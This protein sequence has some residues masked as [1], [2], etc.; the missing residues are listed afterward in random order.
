M[1]RCWCPRPLRPVC[2]AIVS[3]QY[4]YAYAAVSVDDGRLDTLVLPHVNAECM[5]LF[6]DELS[7][8]HRSERVVL[9]LDGAGWHH[10]AALQWPTN[11]RPL[12]L[13]PYSPELNPV[14]HLWDELREKHFHNPASSTPWKTSRSIWPTHWPVL[15]AMLHAFTPSLR[16]LGSLVHFQ[17]EIGMR[18]ARWRSDRGCALASRSVDRSSQHFGRFE[19]R[20]LLGKSG[21]RLARPCMC[22]RNHRAGARLQWTG[23]RG[24]RSHAAA[25][26]GQAAGHASRGELR[27]HAGQLPSDVRSGRSGLWREMSWRTW[28]RARQVE[29]MEVDEP[30]P[31]HWS[32]RLGLLRSRPDPVGRAPMRG[33]PSARIVAH[34]MSHPRRSCQVHAELVRHAPGKAAQRSCRSSSPKRIDSG[35]ISS[36]LSPSSTRPATSAGMPCACA[37]STVRCASSARTNSAKPAPMLSVL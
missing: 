25:G 15:N 14:E 36:C 6:V 30:Y 11:V 7:R 2:R 19:V 26:L 1:R 32:Q 31:R 33:G 3:R 34:A 24:T 37:I 27:P 12:H 10:H 22:M 9:V 16:G 4:T 17:I 5:Q 8:R 35:S 29:E 20:R 23:L 21:V 28:R 13:P 18:Q